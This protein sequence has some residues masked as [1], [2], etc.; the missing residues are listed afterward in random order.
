MCKFA[1]FSYSSLCL[2]VERLEKKIAAEMFSSV[3]GLMEMEKKGFYQ[4]LE[5]CSMAVLVQQ[6]SCPF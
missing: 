6:P 4:E 2:C 1:Y 5:E 3:T